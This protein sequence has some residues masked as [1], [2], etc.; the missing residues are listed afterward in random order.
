VSPTK[1][2]LSPGNHLFR[3]WPLFFFSLCLSRDKLRLRRFFRLPLV[4][5][6]SCLFFP[7]SPCSPQ[8]IRYSCRF[9]PVRFTNSSNISHRLPVPPQSPCSTAVFP[10]SCPPQPSKRAAL[11][12]SVAMAAARGSHSSNSLELPFQTLS[13]ATTCDARFP[14]TLL[15]I[16]IC[17]RKCSDRRPLLSF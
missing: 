10:L 7:E 5:S 9:S 16:S 12:V 14:P 6:C 2:T 17:L 15:Q 4:D 8:S 3:L 11:S 1:E 13:P